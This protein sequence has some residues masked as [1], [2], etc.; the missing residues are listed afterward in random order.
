MLS[1]MEAEFGCSVASLP[2]LLKGTSRH[3]WG[4]NV[5]STVSVKRQLLLFLQGQQQEAKFQAAIEP[6]RC[7]Q[8][9]RRAVTTWSQALQCSLLLYMTVSANVS[10]KLLH[11]NVCLYEHSYLH[12]N[13]WSW[14]QAIKPLAL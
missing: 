14:L 13:N 7:S 10:T 12:N 9:T 4:I 11:H 2:A 5:N 8:V 1:G 6:T 3:V